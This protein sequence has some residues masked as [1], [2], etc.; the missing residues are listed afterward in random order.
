VD[1]LRALGNGVVPAVVAEFL[2]R[3]LA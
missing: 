3:V 2:R 1:R